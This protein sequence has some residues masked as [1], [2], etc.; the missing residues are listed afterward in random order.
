VAS[1]WH[2]DPDSYLEMVRS[3]IP[4]YEELQARLASATDVVTA[5]RILDLG[6]GTGV[7]ARHVLATHPGAELV[8]IDASD[9]MLT[10]ARALLPSATFLVAR[11]EDRLPAGPFDLVVSAFAVHH[12]DGPGK[13][14]LFGR[15][16][17]AL[18]PGGRFVLCDVVVPTHPVARPVPLDEGFDLPSTVEEQL[19][20]LDAVHLQPHVVFA[21]DDLAIIAADRA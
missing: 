7:T 20:W 12:L 1:Q 17:S 9:S 18:A 3:E 4:C 5:R 6:S 13:A 21:E 14:D 15:V 11:L 2:F 10:H 19:E 16:A 8:G